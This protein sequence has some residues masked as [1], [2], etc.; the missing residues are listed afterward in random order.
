LVCP[1]TARAD[2]SPDAALTRVLDRARAA[3]ASSSACAQP[4]IDRLVNIFCAG[5]IRIGVRNDY[6][7]FGWRVDGNR[8]GY[9]IDIARAVAKRLGVALEFVNAKAATR[10]PML[11]DGRID[12]AIA[13]MGD[14]TQRRTQVR[15]IAP[16]YY[17]SETVVVGRRELAL[18]DW[19]DIRGRTVC[20]SVGN[21]SN[22]EFIS[23]GV[24]LM[25]FDDAAALIQRL[26]D[27]TCILAAQD[28]S[29]FAGHFVDSTFAARF[30]E[31]YGFAPVPWGMGV[32]L[33]NSAM[34]AQA[35]G[36]ISQTFHRDGVF[37]NA[38][39]ANRIATGFLIQ[40]E[41]LWASPRCNRVTGV[42]DP[43]CILPPAN[44]ELAPTTFAAIV[45]EF[46]TWF[47]SKTGSDLRLP[48][49]E[50]APAWSLFLTGI[51]NSL[52]L[53]GGA[54]LATLVFALLFGAA[55]GSRWRLLRWTTSGVTVALQSSP[56]VLTLVISATTT[57]A[58]LL[59]SEAATLG[60]AILALGLANGSNAGQA[61]AEAYIIVR[62]ESGGAAIVPLFLFRRS[63]SRSATQIVAF[64]INAAKGTPIAS[65]IGAPELLNALT[66]ITAFASGRAI[67]Y[68]LLLVFYTSIVISVVW[69][70]RRF[71]H[72]LERSRPAT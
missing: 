55:M 18:S 59:Y 71:Q 2:E 57:H 26:E 69:L 37:L 17:R 1:L 64:L 56:I 7:L 35:L 32:P 52:I 28:D 23:R 6:P 19:K 5:R 9:E 13:A 72:L 38:A 29:F 3:A 60:A 43:A 22:A 21:G 25:L 68:T 30:S 39:R 61:I 4:E 24:R 45:T 46:E 14:N 63:I 15:F 54:L 12:L 62:N 40:Q 34:L 27:Q 50:T 36:F 8:R 42:A 58:L 47:R 66:D 67:T 41:A 16:H 10:V 53:I 44:V 65:F 49:L 31:K 33:E 11:A 20:V 70:C 51:F 48:M